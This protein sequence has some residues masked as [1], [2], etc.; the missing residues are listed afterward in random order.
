[1]P[2]KMVKKARATNIEVA[3]K[4]FL[5]VNPL[6]K[7]YSKVEYIL[8]D[9][10]CSGSGIVN[11]FDFINNTG[12]QSSTTDEQENSTEEKMNIEGRLKSLS[13]FQLSTLLHAFK[14]PNVKR[15]VYSTCS[16]NQEEN[17]D[18]VKQALSAQ[19]DFKLSNN[20]FP[21]WH[22]RGNDCFDGA[23]SCIRTIPKHDLTI[24][25]FVSCFER[26]INCESKKFMGK[27]SRQEIANNI[28]TSDCYTD[29]TSSLGQEKTQKLTKQKKRKFDEV[30]DTNT[31]ANSSKAKK[32]K[33]IN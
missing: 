29:T 14:F 11:R 19:N 32:F 7:Q 21:E 4:D 25:F 6:D 8:L 5:Q 10:S 12:N 24:G 13:K 31:Y 33:Q 22:R 9:P 30:S 15:V 1:M 16:I 23:T 18:V 20:I 27:V 26:V 3:N 17:E 28:K 2:Q